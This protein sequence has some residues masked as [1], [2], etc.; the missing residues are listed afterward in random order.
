MERPRSRVGRE[1]PEPPVGGFPTGGGSPPT[2]RSSAPRQTAPASPA[3]FRAAERRVPPHLVPERMSPAFVGL[4][5][6]MVLAIG[7]PVVLR[8]RQERR[9]EEI[10]HA[11]ATGDGRGQFDSGMVEDLPE[12]ARRYFLHALEPGAPLASSVSLTLPGSIRMSRAGDPLPL[13]SEEILTA[14]RGYVW[15]ARI[16]RGPLTIRGFDV[17][18]DGEGEMRWWVAGLVPVVRADGDDVSRSAAGRLVEESALFLPSSLL[19]FRGARWEA[20]DDST[21]RVRVGSD[22]EEVELT[23]ELDDDGGL[24]RLSYPRWNA[25]PKHGPVGHLPF[26][27]DQL[28]EEQTFDGHTLPTR[29]RAGWRLGEVDEFPFFFIRGARATFG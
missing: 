3:T 5:L 15:T 29:F 10:G 20:V 28:G 25:D 22:D 1:N 9:V 11:L 16:R 6:L 17:Y 4:A 13:A 19:P 12:P 24:S 18:T 21:A 14:G 26:V 8:V 27:T 2:E 7:L 23:L